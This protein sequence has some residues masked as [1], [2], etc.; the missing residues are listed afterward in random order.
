MKCWI[1]NLIGRFLIAVVNENG[2]GIP[3][4]LWHHLT[5]NLAPL[6]QYERGMARRKFLY[7]IR[8]RT[9]GN[10]IKFFSW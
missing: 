7:V 8:N 5:Q 9:R 1:H 10:Y 6:S 2:L 4:K 3:N